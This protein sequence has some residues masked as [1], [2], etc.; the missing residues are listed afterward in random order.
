[1]KKKRDAT[2]QDYVELGQFYILNKK[3]T[4]AIKQF[5]LALQIKPDAQAYYQLGLAYE[6][7]NEIALAQEMFRK[8]LELN[9]SLTEASEHLNNITK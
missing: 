7:S 9:C 4:E 8:A 1:M 2:A 6:A 3:Y 5:K